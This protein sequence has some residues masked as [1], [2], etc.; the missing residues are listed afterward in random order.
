MKKLMFQVF[1]AMSIIAF[2]ALALACA[3]PPPTPARPA[4]PPPPRNQLVSREYID[5]DWAEPSAAIVRD[6]V[7]RIVDANLRRYRFYNVWFR[8]NSNSATS[9]WRNRVNFEEYINPQYTLVLLDFNYFC[10][11]FEFS[12]QRL[13]SG[14]VSWR[15]SPFFSG[16][17]L[18][19]FT[20]D[21]NE[22]LSRV[23]LT[24]RGMTFHDRTRHE[25]DLF[26]IEALRFAD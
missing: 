21:V 26:W 2:T 1:G 9:H 15:E 7:M 4:A 10:I 17:G 6:D 23:S 24:M 13:T 5:V 19:V 3:S 12:N 14:G 22:V 16:S 11:G 18:R 25:V 8:T 20:R